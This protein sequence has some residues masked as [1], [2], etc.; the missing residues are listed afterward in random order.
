MGFFNVKE[1]LFILS[2]KPNIWKCTQV[3]NFLLFDKCGNPNENFDFYNR[4][5]LLPLKTLLTIGWHVHLV[6]ID[7]MI[8]GSVVLI[9]VNGINDSLELIKQA[10]NR[11]CLLFLSKS[12][13][14]NNTTA[15]HVDQSIETAILIKRWLLWKV[16]IF[17]K[18][19]AANFC[20]LYIVKGWANIFWKTINCRRLLVHKMDFG[21]KFVN[22]FRISTHAKWT[23]WT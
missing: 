21:S 15:S 1:I 22:S 9:L 20:S 18:N 10:G 4:K 14:F 3:H 6:F 13:W 17:S 2:L 23:K 16:R 12:F 8:I 11:L 7:T 19:N 5:V